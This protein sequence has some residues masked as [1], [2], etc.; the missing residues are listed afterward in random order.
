MQR[1]YLDLDNP[2]FFQARD[3]G[4]AGV[5]LR[6]NTSELDWRAQCFSL[7]FTTT[8]LSLDSLN[9]FFPSLKVPSIRNL[10]PPGSVSTSSPPDLLDLPN[11]T[12]TFRSAKHLLS[13][14]HLSCGLCSLFCCNTA[15]PSLP[16]EIHRNTLLRNEESF[17][18][19]P[20]SKVAPTL[21]LPHLATDTC[22]LCSNFSFHR[23]NPCDRRT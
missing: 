6:G 10:Q 20:N 13:N 5:R 23:R 22:Y 12:T 2:S 15:L 9:G 11:G 16:T 14:P 8:P 1:P 21:P 17:L 3:Q 18:E 4:P 19:Y 7:L